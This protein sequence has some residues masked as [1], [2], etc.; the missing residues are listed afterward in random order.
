M[1][2]A[3][4]R[5]EKIEDPVLVMEDRFNKNINHHFRQRLAKAI[6]GRRRPARRAG[7][8][9]AEGT[10]ELFNELSFHLL[11][12][13]EEQAGVSELAFENRT[14]CTPEDVFAWERTN[15]PYKLPGDLKAFLA[16]FDGLRFSWRVDM[17]NR[18]NITVGSMRLHRLRD[19]LQLPLDADDDDGLRGGLRKCDDDDGDGRPGEGQVLAAFGIEH[20]PRVGRARSGVVLVILARRPMTTPS[21]FPFSRCPGPP[22]AR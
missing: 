7:R 14:G 4:A 11:S 2:W 10:A 3:S 12:Y 22:R 8:A 16:A 18:G 17:T 1:A 9:M 6:A 21:G 19:V 20:Y 5:Q 15:A 13:L